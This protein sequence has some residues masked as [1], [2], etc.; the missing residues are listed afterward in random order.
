VLAGCAEGEPIS[1]SDLK[2]VGKAGG[3]A[4]NSDM[5]AAGGSNFGS[6]G[7][8]MG[9][10]GGSGGDNGSSGSIAMGDSG[11]AGAATGDSGMAGGGNVYD[12]PLSTGLLV[13]Y[14]AQSG[15]PLAFQVKITNN[16]SDAP[17]LSSFS[18]RYFLSSDVVSDASSIVFDDAAWHSGSNMAPYYQGPLDLTPKATYAKLAPTKPMADAYFEFAC[19][20]AGLTLGSKDTLEFHIRSSA[21]AEDQTNDYSYQ[22]GA[23]MAPNPHIVVLQ[24]SNVVAGM[25]P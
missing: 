19:S 4:G 8:D 5:L 25:A 2:A 6:S 13:E 11:T 23:A 12:G 16:G 10:S 24:G 9:S 14:V 20:K 22:A 18:V 15:K 7:S 3:H 17:P 21:I 1:E